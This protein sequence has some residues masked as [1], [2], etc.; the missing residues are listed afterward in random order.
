MKLVHSSRSSYIQY[1][2][3]LKLSSLV[4]CHNYKPR[5]SGSSYNTCELHELKEVRCQK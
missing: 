3:E 1:M 2:H 5:T 4:H